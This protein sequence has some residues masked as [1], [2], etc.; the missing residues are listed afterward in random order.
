MGPMEPMGQIR[1]M[2]GARVSV[3][4]L[5]I[6]LL[7]VVCCVS[8]V[9]GRRSAA[10]AQSTAELRTGGREIAN[11]IAAQK[12]AVTGKPEGSFDISRKVG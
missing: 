6:G 11:D 5:L 7:L 2:A 1:R 4:P 8:S 10:Q 3:T 12:I 9:I